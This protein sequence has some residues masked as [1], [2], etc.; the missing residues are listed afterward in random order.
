MIAKKNAFLIALMAFFPSIQAVPVSAQYPPGYY[1]PGA[2]GG[3]YPGRAG[4]TLYGSAAVINA[5][6][7]VA[8]QQEQARIEREK[9]NQAKLETKKQT[10]DLMMY[11]KANTP[12]STEEQEKVD[13][14]ILRRVMTKPTEVEIKTGK[15]HNIMLPYL[16]QL[17]LAGVPGPPIPINPQMLKSINVTV[18][19][20]GNIGLLKNGG[21]LDWPFALRGKRQEKLDKLIPDA[22]RATLERKLAP[23]LYNEI[24]GEVAK[25]K[26][27]LRTNFHQEKIDGGAYL[28][29]SH[30]LEGLESALT[31]LRDPAAARILDGT[32]QPQ[33][34]NVPELV[35]SMTTQGLKFAPANPGDESV[36]Y[37]LHG[38]MSAYG[39]AAQSQAGFQ[40]G[41]R[42]QAPPMPGAPSYPPKTK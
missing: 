39:Q 12:T 15:A 5:Q 9:A 7:N 27:E 1:P 40:A 25:M 10:F 34:R 28:E 2:Y 20:K 3:Y 13:A 14:M 37:A 35:L 18:G 4:G 36:Y 38:S 24:T 29:G 41:H 33:G 8:V 31:M 42:A 23:P 26:E 22:V 17:T 6:G 11:E 16:S 32:L 21:V 19:T 30:Y